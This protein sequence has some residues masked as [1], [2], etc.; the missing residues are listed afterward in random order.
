MEAPYPSM[1]CEFISDAVN[2]DNG[3][4][5][6]NQCI[7]NGFRRHEHFKC[8]FRIADPRIHPHPKTVPPNFKV[9]SFFEYVSKFSLEA[10]DPILFLAA[11][12]HVQRFTGRRSG[13]RR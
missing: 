5:I 4:D 1:E 3:N 11:N 12:E 2:A 7:P 6:A 8:F 10:C 13:T 9:D